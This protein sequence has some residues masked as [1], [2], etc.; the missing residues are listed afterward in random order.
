[1]R[2]RN[3]LS[4][5][6][7]SVFRRNPI[8]EQIVVFPVDRGNRPRQTV[9]NSKIKKL[10]HQQPEHLETCPF[11]TGNESLTPPTLF[12]IKD[13]K[14]GD[15]LTR[16]VNNAF[17]AVSPPNKNASADEEHKLLIHANI[18]NA[19]RPAIGYHE[20][21]IENR[22]HN[23]VTSK[24]KKED[25]KRLVL[26]WWNRGNALCD[27]PSIQ[28]ILYFKNQGSVAG[29]SLVHPHAQLVALPFV[30]RDVRV[31][32]LSN[33]NYFLDKGVSVFEKTIEEEMLA[34]DYGCNNSDNSLTDNDGS[35]VIEQNEHF[36]SIIPFAAISPFNVWI[37]PLYPSAHFINSTMEELDSFNDILWSSV[38]RLDMTLNE[39]DFNM[40][41]KSAPLASRHKQAAFNAD[42]YFRWYLSITPRLGAGAMA[43]FELGSGIFSNGNLPEDDAKILRECLPEDI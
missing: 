36:I 5:R 22:R 9:D 4:R 16:V 20:V 23:A 24:G 7:Y 34:R 40:L 32:Q 2:L 21:I 13:E 19:E 37:I 35:R 33:L 30:P 18:L 17:P 6:Q 39:P 14:S 11:C 42:T 26:S 8:T 15:W 3:L 25:I 10:S 1:M 38:R 27:D 28:H 31:G 12:Q 29:A 41:I 43:G